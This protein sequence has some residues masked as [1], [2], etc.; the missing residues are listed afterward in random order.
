MY[1][2]NITVRRRT[3]NYRVYA[4]KAKRRPCFRS[5]LISALN[6]NSDNMVLFDLNPIISYLSTS[7]SYH[8]AF[9]FSSPPQ[10]FSLLAS[11]H[12]HVSVALQPEV[13]VSQKLAEIP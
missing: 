5:I 13:S 2:V 3:N 8:P 9:T 4:S 12:S 7:Q 6:L 10:L 11:G 1:G